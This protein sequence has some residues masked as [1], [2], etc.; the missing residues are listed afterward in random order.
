MHLNFSH[1]F[2]FFF[3]F[4]YFK[5]TLFKR[6]KKKKEENF[7]TVNNFEKK[8]C[9]ISEI[10]T[11]GHE[12]KSWP[13]LFLREKKHNAN[14]KK[15]KKKTQTSVARPFFTDFGCFEPIDL[16]DNKSTSSI[17]YSTLQIFRFPFFLIFFLIYLKIN[18]YKTRVSL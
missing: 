5:K 16:A 9:G 18:V 3:F 10:N 6:E 15:K 13:K 2:F 1:F 17:R 11:K 7:V 14:K 8:Q 12:Y 4:P